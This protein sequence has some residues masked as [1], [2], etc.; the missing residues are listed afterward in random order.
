MK[1]FKIIATHLHIIR[2][3]IFELHITTPQFLEPPPDAQLVSSFACQVNLL[4]LIAS[5]TPKIDTKQRTTLV[6]LLQ[7]L[8]RQQVWRTDHVVQ[9]M[10]HKAHS[11]KKLVALFK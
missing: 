3:H 4:S 9:T 1:P 6:L 5:G 11:F 7:D 2:Q 10:H 8:P